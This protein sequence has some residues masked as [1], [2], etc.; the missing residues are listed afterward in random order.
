MYIL[1]SFYT[2]FITFNSEWV[3][4]FMTC[5]EFKVKHNFRGKPRK[6]M[7]VRAAT[8]NSMIERPK[9][10]FRESNRDH[11]SYRRGKQSLRVRSKS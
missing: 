9:D 6:A 2:F 4:L 7:K 10:R 1:Y 8:K 11:T 5:S 3:V